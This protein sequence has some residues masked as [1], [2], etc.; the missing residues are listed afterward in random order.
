MKTTTQQ[1]RFQQHAIIVNGKRYGVRYQSGALRSYPEGTITV[2]AKEY[3]YIPRVDGMMIENNTDS[4]TDYFEKDTIRI[5]PDSIYYNDALQACTKANAK[6]E[7]R[8]QQ[9]LAKVELAHN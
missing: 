4:M 8:W 7:A 6:R 9:Y 5:T 1:V 3:G 2:Y